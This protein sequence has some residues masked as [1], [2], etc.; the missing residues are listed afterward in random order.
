MIMGT[1][2]LDY[3]IHVKTPKLIQRDELTDSKDRSVVLCG[4]LE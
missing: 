2:K 1:K 3:S 4:A